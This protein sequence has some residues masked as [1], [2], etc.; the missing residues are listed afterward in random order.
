MHDFEPVIEAVIGALTADLSVPVWDGLPEGEWPPASGKGWVIVRHIPG[1]R[2]LPTL[3]DDLSVEEFII[4]LR[5]YGMQRRQASWLSDKVAHAMLDRAGAGFRVPIA[6]LTHRALW[7]GQRM[8]AM[9]DGDQPN[10]LVWVCPDRYALVA[11]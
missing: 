3:G 11:G 4:E 7:L 1:G 5:S 8:G 2:G 6:G 10:R 9:S